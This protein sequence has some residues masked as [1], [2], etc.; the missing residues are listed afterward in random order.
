MRAEIFVCFHFS[1]PHTEN[2]PFA[3]KELNKY[4]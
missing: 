4:L 3:E 1:N 2:S